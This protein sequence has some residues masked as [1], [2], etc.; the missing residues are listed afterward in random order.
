MYDETNVPGPDYQVRPVIRYAVTAYYHPY[1][2][3]D[4]KVGS[5]G[6]H[7]VLAECEN[8]HNADEIVR[9]LRAEF[10]T[11]QSAQRSTS[12]PAAGA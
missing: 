12:E 3:L 2:S 10:E 11:M 6:C 7:K 4:G 9:A 5:S 8:E 1:Q